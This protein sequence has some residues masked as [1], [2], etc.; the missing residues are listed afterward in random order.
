M[1]LVDLSDVFEG[2]EVKAFGAS[3][4]Q[5]ASCSSPVPPSPARSW[6][7]STEQAKQLGAKGLAWFRVTAGEGGGLA[8]DSPLDRF[9]SERGAG[10]P[11]G[12]PPAASRATWSWSSPTS[13]A[14]PARCSGTL[15]VELGRPPGERGS[16]PIRVGGRLPAVRR[17]RRRPAVR[18]PAHHPFTMPHPEDLGAAGDR[19]RSPC[20]RRPTT[21]CSTGGSWVRGASGS[22]GATS[23]AGSSPRSGIGDEEAEA[24]FGFLLGAFRY[25]APPHAG[26][27]VGIDRLVAI[28]AGEENIREVIAFPK[29]QS[30]LGPHDRGAQAARPRGPGRA[31]APV[32]VPPK[33]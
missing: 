8:L 19:S 12:R 31:R 1:E 6:T 26:F 7:A 11:G 22:T 2:T 10:R 21:S 9:L 27:A 23:R 28:F 5:G 29:T 14:W 4:G 17:R 30:G 32:V 18:W 25:G 15:R 24:R 3:D 20:A 13:T 33:D 16:A